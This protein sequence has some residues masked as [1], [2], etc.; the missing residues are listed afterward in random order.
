V[1]CK[2]N[3]EMFGFQPGPKQI[4]PHTIIAV[5]AQLA[6]FARFGE[7]RYCLTNALVIGLRI[8]VSDVSIE[9]GCAIFERLG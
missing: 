8:G 3:A 2:N 7:P 5:I 9:A 1:G 6:R 4:E